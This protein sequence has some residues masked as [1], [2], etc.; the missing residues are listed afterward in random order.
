MLFIGFAIK[1]ADLR[2]TRCSYWNYGEIEMQRK[3]YWKIM[4][5]VAGNKDL[6]KH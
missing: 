4:K 1:M 5:T 3:F 6:R 2:F